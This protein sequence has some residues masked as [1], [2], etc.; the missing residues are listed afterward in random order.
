MKKDELAL[1]NDLVVKKNENIKIMKEYEETKVLLED[2]KKRN[3][4]YLG[5]IK[6]REYLIMEY[7]NQIKKL[8]NEI[9]DKNE[10][11]K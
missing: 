1:K 7:N 6:D 5:M 2:M 9:N 4:E 3:L 10:Q 8:D 11:I